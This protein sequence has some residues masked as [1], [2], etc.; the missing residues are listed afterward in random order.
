MP[1]SPSPIPSHD[2]EPALTPRQGAKIVGCSL[3][4]FWP[5]LH[6]GAI[7]AY[8]IGKLIRVRPEDLRAYVA[9]QREAFAVS[10]GR[11]A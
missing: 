8:R 9:A 5:L 7:P 4:S 10:A 6:S 11:A 2:L 1:C 3:S